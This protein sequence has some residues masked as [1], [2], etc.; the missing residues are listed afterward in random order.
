MLKYIKYILLSIF[1]TACLCSYSQ[2]SERNLLK[3]YL[4]LRSLQ[5]DYPYV[6]SYTTKGKK[7]EESYYYYKN[8]DYYILAFFQKGVDSVKEKRYSKDVLFE[9]IE[10][11]IKSLNKLKT[12]RRNDSEFRRSFADSTVYFNQI[13][14]RY[15]SL[16]YNH[17]QQADKKRLAT[18][19]NEKLLTGYETLNFIAA[20]LNEQ[21]PGNLSK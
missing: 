11:N 21:I 19:K 10:K 14:V 1:L 12:A 8:D 2:T 20:F 13:G 4:G 15:K 6:Y 3:E 5:G 18:I 9:T 16:H 7:L 17:Y